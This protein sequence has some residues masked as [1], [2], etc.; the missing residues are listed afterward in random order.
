MTAICTVC[1]R[2]WNISIR[3]D[4]RGYICPDCAVRKVLINKGIIKERRN[5]SEKS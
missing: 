3:Q 5:R 1:G 2:R 4:P